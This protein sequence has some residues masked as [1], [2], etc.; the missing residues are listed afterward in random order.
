MIDLQFDHVYKCY[1]IQQDA[2]ASDEAT[3][4]L[5]RLKGRVGRLRQ[6]S[7]DFL[8][9]RDVS[10]DVQRGEAVGIIGHNGAGK[11]TILKLLS[12]I[13]TPTSGSITINGRLA[14]LIEVGSGFHPELSGRENIYLNGSILG[15]SRREIGAKL[16]KI[17][18]FAGLRE[19][20]DVPVKRYS[21]GYVRPPRLLY[22]RAFR[23]GYIV[24]RR[25]ARRR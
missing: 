7:Q 24:A 14:A 19:F 23:A 8:A 9:V 16:D 18:E 12:N 13:T 1:R 6:R 22:R 5:A 3:G 15:M 20:I 10:F 11:S 17:V 21:S 25:G 4:T 2:T